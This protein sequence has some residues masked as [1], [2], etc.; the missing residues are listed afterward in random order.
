VYSGAI[1]GHW[2]GGF[3]SPQR[4]PTSEEKCGLVRG[5]CFQPFQS[6]SIYWSRAT[7]AH[8]VGL[9]SPQIGRAW[10]AQAWE[11]GRLGYPTGPER[12][13]STGWSQTFQGGT[14]VWNSR[15]NRVTRR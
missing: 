7:G 2:G 5:G 15:T 8:T 10:A 14:L 12:R 3:S 9:R 1:S 11:R 13:L 6:G 4:F